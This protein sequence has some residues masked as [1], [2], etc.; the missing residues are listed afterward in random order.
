[1]FW[2]SILPPSLQY[3]PPKCCTMLQLR[4]PPSTSPNYSLHQLVYSHWV[5]GYVQYMEEHTNTVEGN[6][7]HHTNSA[8][9]Q[10]TVD[11]VKRTTSS[12]NCSSAPQ[13]APV[14]QSETQQHFNI[15]LL[16]ICYQGNQ[17][18]TANWYVQRHGLSYYKQLITEKKS[19]KP[20]LIFC[21]VCVCVCVWGGGGEIE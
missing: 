18:H 15:L 19:I 7:R 14:L 21:S 4:K 1:M 2:R 5:N 6:R 16:V 13:T 8:G 12:V 9:T 10:K 11:W 3:V 17:V 20:V